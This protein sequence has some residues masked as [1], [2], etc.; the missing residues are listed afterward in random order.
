MRPAVWH[1]AGKGRVL[2]RT[3][4]KQ[5]RTLVLIYSHTGPVSDTTLADWMEVLAGQIGYFKRD[6][7]RALHREKMLE[8]DETTGEIHLSPLGIREV[9]DRLAGALIAP[10]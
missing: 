10:A 2:D 3:L 5:M 9:E 8:Y 7:L 6:V 4:K 1:V